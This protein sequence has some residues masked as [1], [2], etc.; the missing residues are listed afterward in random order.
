MSGGNM[1]EYTKKEIDS[2][3]TYRWNPRD[4]GG[5]KLKITKSSLGQFLWCP[6]AYRY[7][8]IEQIRG[9]VSDVM[10]K[11]NKVHDAEEKF[12][13][14]F[15]VKKAAKIVEENKEELDEYVRSVYPITDHEGAEEIINKMST[16]YTQEFLA[17]HANNELDNFIPVGNEIM[18]DADIT[19][20]GTDIHFQGIIDRIFQEG[21][22]YIL[23]E[24]KTGAWKDSKKTYMRKEMAFYKVLYEAASDEQKKEFGLDP[25]IPI[26]QWGWYFPASNHMSI[27]N[28]L[29][30]SESGV[31][32]S[33]QNLIMAYFQDEFKFT[34]FY[35]KCIHCGHLDICEASG[36]QG[37]DNYDW[38]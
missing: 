14:K 37:V 30:R 28:C 7:S 26:K 33:I 18:L 32:N 19:F 29:T 13:N 3:F 34:W 1:T 24:L 9:A 31:W 36:K 2:G 12:W 38:F 20:Q 25:A 10:I 17:S 6:A 23:M 15:D 16:F 22:H 5:L 8:Y 11:G 27:E 35:K 21:D 4:D